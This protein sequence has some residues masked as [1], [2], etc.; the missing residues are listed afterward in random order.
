MPTARSSGPRRVLVTGGSGGLGRWVVRELLGHGYTVVS[1]DRRPPEEPEVGVRYAE[2][3]LTDVKEVERALD[4]CDA[5][6]HLA[7]IPAPGGRPDEEVFANNVLGTFAVF[8]AASHLGVGRVVAA[9]STAALGAAFAPQPFGPRYVPIDEAHPLLPQDPY[10]L[11]KEVGE[12]VGAAFGRRGGLSV[13]ALRFHHV[14]Q[15]GEA[16]RLAAGFEPGSEI[17]ARELGGYVDVRDAA[18]ACRLGLE[19]P[20]PGFEA[21][22]ITAADTLSRTPTLELVR[23]HFP[24]VEVRASLAGPVSAWSIAKAERLLGYVPRYSWR[25]EE[26]DDPS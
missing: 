22:H 18:R 6:V 2:L 19:A 4:G 5:A 23:R 20:P 7:A 16:A 26:P 25:T 21:F 3:E 14:T 17:A 8:Q 10:G 11:S 1:A 15:P 13:T 9:S 12:R 24:E